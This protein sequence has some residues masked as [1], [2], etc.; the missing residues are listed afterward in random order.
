MSDYDNT[1]R[2][3]LFK[4]TAMREGKKDANLQGT[5]NVEGV[6]YWINGW[7]GETKSGDKY[8]SGSIRKKEKQSAPSPAASE[9][10]ANFEDDIPF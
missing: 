7:T 1:N 4:N 6:E 2:F 8:I 10:A 3:A 5:L 9:R